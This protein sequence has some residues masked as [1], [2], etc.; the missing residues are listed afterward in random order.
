MNIF[1][2]LKK[3]DRNWDRTKPDVLANQITD[4][5]QKV[6]NVSER[7]AVEERIFDFAFSGARL[8]KKE[9]KPWMRGVA[10]RML[11]ENSL[12]ALAEL[13]SFGSRVIRRNS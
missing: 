5:M 9:V 13:G 7:R 12:N 11:V 6:T 4:L 1:N 2:V 3:L 8:L 10:R